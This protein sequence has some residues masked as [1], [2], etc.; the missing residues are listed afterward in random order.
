MKKMGLNLFVYFF[1]NGVCRGCVEEDFVI[2]V[3]I[4]GVKFVLFVGFVIFV[5]SVVWKVF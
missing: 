5:Y 2:F 4:L 3:F 1:V